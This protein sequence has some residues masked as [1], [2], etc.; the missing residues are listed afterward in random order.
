MLYEVSARTNSARNDRR[1]E[2][3]SARNSY[4]AEQIYS[5]L[6]FTCEF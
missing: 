5:I 1:L 6:L 2:G 3:V 4:D